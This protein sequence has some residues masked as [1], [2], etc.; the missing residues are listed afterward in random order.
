MT[1]NL[2]GWIMDAKKGYKQGIS[3]S[4]SSTPQKGISKYSVK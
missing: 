4:Q 3:L 1:N 2:L